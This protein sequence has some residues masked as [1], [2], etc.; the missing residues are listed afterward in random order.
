MFKKYILFESQTGFIELFHHFVIILQT[1]KCIRVS[2]S[3]KFYYRVKEAPIIEKRETL[4][5]VLTFDGIYSRFYS[6]DF[7]YF[8]FSS[9]YLA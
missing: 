9:R 1:Y 3:G 8:F 4:F 5:Y 2:H 7:G 6:V